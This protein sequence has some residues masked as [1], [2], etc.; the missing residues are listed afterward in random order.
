[1]PFMRWDDF[2]SSIRARGAAP[3]VAGKSTFLARS[4]LVA[5]R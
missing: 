5:A 4:V 1:M 2:G 3:A